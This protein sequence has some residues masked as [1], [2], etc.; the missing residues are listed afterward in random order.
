MEKW[1]HV[2]IQ[3]GFGKVSSV[4]VA[5]YNDYIAW[6][7][8][9]GEMKKVPRTGIYHLYTPSIDKAIEYLKEEFEC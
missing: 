1:W 7:D 2:S 9:D 6:L 8:I 4:T 5:K 3:G